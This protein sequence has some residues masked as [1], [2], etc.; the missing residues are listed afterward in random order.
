MGLNPLKR[1]EPCSVL[2]LEQTRDGATNFG[3][4][5]WLVVIQYPRRKNTTVV[6]KERK[7]I[8]YS[9]CIRNPCHVY[10]VRMAHH[11]CT[12]CPAHVFQQKIGS[13]ETPSAA[14]QT[15]QSLISG[16][17]TDV[18]LCRGFRWPLRIN[19]LCR[20]GGLAVPFMSC[21]AWDYPLS[22]RIIALCVSRWECEDLCLKPYLNLD[23]YDYTEILLR[24][25]FAMTIRLF[26]Y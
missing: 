10:S 24:V 9:T 13:A 2:W 21:L 6:L 25:W 22:I 3:P 7:R 11:R 19:R 15:R 26:E 20:I 4:T 14:P 18:Q 12:T 8:K 1:T 16:I 23:I 5:E 17:C